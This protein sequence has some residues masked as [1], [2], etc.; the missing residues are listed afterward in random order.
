[1][2]TS[3]FLRILVLV[4]CIIFFGT[5]ILIVVKNIASEGARWFFDILSASL[6]LLIFFW[7]LAQEESLKQ[8]H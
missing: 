2:E 5:G 8:G 7:L 3:D 6:F 4:T 1:M